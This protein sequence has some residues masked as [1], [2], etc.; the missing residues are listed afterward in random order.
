MLS[1]GTKTPVLTCVCCT[2]RAANP[3]LRSEIKMKQLEYC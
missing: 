2:H 1:P 3:V